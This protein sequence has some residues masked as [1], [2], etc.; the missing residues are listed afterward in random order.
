MNRIRFYS[1]LILLAGLAGG[2]FL[3]AELLKPAVGGA[4]KE[5]LIIS[6][7]RRL[8]YTVSE[9]GLVYEVNG[10]RRLE[11]ISRRVVNNKRK[12]SHPFD[13]RIVIDG[14]DTVAVRHGYL[15]DRRIRSVQ[16]PNHYVTYSGNY[17]INLPDGKH[18][19]EIITGDRS[20]GPVLVRVVGKEFA[21]AG[22]K[23]TNL[24]PTVHQSALHLVT[25]SHELAYYELSQAV[26]LQVVST[27]PGLLRITSRLAFESWMGGEEI[28]RIK[29]REGNKILGTYFFTT[30]RST[31]ATVREQ[32]EWV[33]AKWRS[34]EIEVPEG[35]H[36]YD[37][38]L[39][40]KDRQVLVRFTE[41]K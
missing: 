31:A 35:R 36:T 38:S 32:P 3:S 28:Y 6:S 13:Y 26:P 30:E 41:I 23:K 33:P 2:E 24:A 39:L 16:H 18:R 27:G 22:G 7:K 15:V 37:I 4:D 11:F 14:S 20:N 19:V 17:F 34:C 21:A 8:Y 25:N 29:V 5:I 12:R 1:T 40:E 9:E 10:P